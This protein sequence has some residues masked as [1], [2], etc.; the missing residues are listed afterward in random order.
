MVFQVRRAAREAPGLLSHAP[1]SVPMSGA[2]TRSRT[3]AR[4]SRRRTWATASAWPAPRCRAYTTAPS[5]SAPATRCSSLLTGRTALGPGLPARLFN[6]ACL[7]AATPHPAVPAPRAS[8]QRPAPAAST[9]HRARVAPSGH[10]TTIPGGILV[11]LPQRTDHGIHGFRSHGM[12]E[13]D[14]A[15]SNDS[16]VSRTKT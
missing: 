9:M 16:S 15:E 6:Q 1:C 11:C 7:F 12:T 3:R 8:S 14:R 10:Q 5:P 2:T 13:S 4:G